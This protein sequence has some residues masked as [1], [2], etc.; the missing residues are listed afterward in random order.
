M[1][2]SQTPRH[3]QEQSESLAALKNTDIVR[4]GT[5]WDIEFSNCFDLKIIMLNLQILITNLFLKYQ[6]CSIA[7][8]I[9]LASIVSHL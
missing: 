9:P 2:F 5:S 1:A 7:V 3:L 6:A 8:L 4:E